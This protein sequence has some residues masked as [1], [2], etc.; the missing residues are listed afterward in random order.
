M[1]EYIVNVDNDEKGNPVLTI[2]G[3]LI[4]CIECQYHGKNSAGKL[5]CPYIDRPVEDDFYCGDG[6]PEENI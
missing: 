1:A 5:Y 6:D 3:R 4:R 2:K